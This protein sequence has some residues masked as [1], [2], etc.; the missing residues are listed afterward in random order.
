MSSFSLF[1]FRFSLSL[2]PLT[3][4]AAEPNIVA[5]ESIAITVS[6]LDRALD[7]YTNVLHFEKTG[8]R[9]VHGPDWESLTG[10]FGCRMRIADL[11]LGEDH[12]QLIDYLTPRSLPIPDDARA[13]DQSFQHIA[14]VVTD[15]DRAYA[16]LRAHKVEHA[17]TAPQTLPESIPAAAGIRAFYFRDP[18]SHF[19]E[20]ISFPQGK[21]DPRWH[22]PTDRLFLGIDHTAIVVEDTETSLCLYRDTLGLKVV[23]TSTN[24]GTEQA[25]LNNIQNARLR[26]TTLR[27]P[28]GPG[29]ELLEY[30]HPEE[31]R[32]APATRAS[33]IAHWH[34]KLRVDSAS[35]GSMIARRL[36]ATD[37]TLMSSET[38]H[39]QPRNEPNL[40][41]RMW[42]D[43]D[44]HAFI[45]TATGG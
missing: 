11:R 38:P 30:L 10:V 7:F 44:Q 35:A 29:I 22:A 20:V 14:I 4:S 42:C 19:L 9:E 32:R 39:L 41:P 31:T 36:T 3:A 5:V 16:H 21:G 34:I 33:D 45:L 28:A 18:D 17:S 23:G 40:L 12:I 2:L 6:D 25:H 24:Q 8:E 27:A 15:I 26:I 1:A 13:N 43:R 37:T